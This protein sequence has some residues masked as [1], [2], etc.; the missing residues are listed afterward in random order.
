MK[1]PRRILQILASRDG[2]Y[3]VGVSAVTDEYDKAE[4]LSAAIKPAVAIIDDVIRKVY[5]ATRTTD[6]NPSSNHELL[7]DGKTEKEDL[8]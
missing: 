5:A 4:R 3:E 1:R 8:R 2:V 6:A 7:E